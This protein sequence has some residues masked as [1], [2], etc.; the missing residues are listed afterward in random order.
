MIFVKSIM[1]KKT[2]FT[3]T[4]N[5]IMANLID[6]LG[7]STLKVW[8]ILRFSKNSLYSKDKK[9][10]IIRT[11][12]IGDALVTIPLFRSLKKVYPEGEIDCLIRP[13]SKDVLENIPYIHRIIQSF[14]RW[15]DIINAIKLKK[16]RYDVVI[17][18]RPDGYFFN[19]FIAF[20]IG[21]KRRVGFAMKGGGFFKRI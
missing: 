11:D 16:Q 18:P 1:L 17:S 5:W 21:G 2:N 3:K 19:H 9:V 14:S 13:N 10:L 4:G 15:G 7:F 8:K 12:G 20:L 6:L